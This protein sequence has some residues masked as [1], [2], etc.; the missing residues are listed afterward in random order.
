VKLWIGGGEIDEVVG[1]CENGDQFSALLVMEKREN[2]LAQKGSREPLHVVFHENLH[3]GTLNGAGP[4]DRQVRPSPDRH[5]G[6]QK[7]FRILIF[8]VEAAVISGEMF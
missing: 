8:A 5:V 4:L 7:N 6:A 2:L 1:V 3:G